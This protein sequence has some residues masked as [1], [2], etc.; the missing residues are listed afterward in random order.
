M[1]R[2]RLSFAVSVGIV[3][4]LLAAACTAGAGSSTPASIAPSVPAATPTAPP[5]ATT[6]ATAQAI[7]TS[8][9]P[10]VPAVTPT[11]LETSAAVATSAAPISSNAPGSG[12]SG[13]YGGTSAPAGMYYVDLQGYR[14]TFTVPSSD[15]WTNHYPW[16]FVAIGKV[17]GSEGP[18][19]RLFLV[20]GDGGDLPTDAC[21]WS[22]TTSTPGPAVN[23]LV[24]ALTDVKGFE[25]TAPSEA[26][27][28]GYHEQHVRLTVPANVDMASCD[29]GQYHGIGGFYDINPGQVQ[30]CWVFEADGA[31]HLFWSAFDGDTPA[32]AQ[33]DLTQLIDSLQ[34]E[35]IAV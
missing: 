12:T 14:Y 35:K 1:I 9:A 6:R 4:S 24:T 28:G 31:R 27:I 2:S 20:G 11:A 25:A 22:H 5:P 21:K 17:H 29:G 19:T 23:D 3:A 16:D 30:D 13:P 7:P 10:T 32:D 26:T 18:M 8:I 34:I 33:A 15:W